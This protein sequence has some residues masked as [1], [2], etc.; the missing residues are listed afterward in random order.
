[1]KRLFCSCIVIIAGLTTSIAPITLL[2]SSRDLSHEPITPIAVIDNLQPNKV[3]LGNRLFHEPRLSADN[4]ISCA[5]CHPVSQSGTDGLTLSIGI[6]GQI[7]DRNT[8]TV[9]NS[10][11][12]FAQFWDGRA[13]T[14]EEQIDGP[15]TNPKEMGSNWPDIIHKLR[16]SH[17][18]RTLFSD[19]Y[20]D[21]I[22]ANNIRDAIATYE[23]SLLTPN[24][25]F[26]RYLKGE[27][28]AIT[29]E[30]LEGYQ[31]FKSYG[32]ISCHQG[33][34]IGGN[35]YEKLGVVIPYYDKEHPDKGRF[36]LTGKEHHRYQFKVPSLRNV[37]LTAPYLHDG[38]IAELDEV[39]QI[40]GR[41]QL[42]RRIPKEKAQQIVAFLK[43]LTGHLE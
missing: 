24:S 43:T 32:C 8:P 11:L 3:Q 22:T 21:G 25:R 26:D 39:V 6:Y 28:E 5:H 14:L 9:L 23:R 13:K 34:A 33:Q 41:H 7:G 30:E 40:M 16:S 38:S 18:Y 19:I 15:I 27:Q 42:G 17:E 35:I 4:T 10:G 12:H 36:T 29:T 31:L 1:M 20:P 37:A 2:A